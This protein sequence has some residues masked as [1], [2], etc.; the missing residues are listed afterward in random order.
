MPDHQVVLIVEAGHHKAGPI[1]VSPK[2]GQRISPKVDADGEPDS[3]CPREWS[4]DIVVDKFSVG[5]SGHES[6]DRVWL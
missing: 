5:V 1:I 3:R 2:V 6:N 4:S